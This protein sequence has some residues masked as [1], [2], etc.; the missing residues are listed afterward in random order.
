VLLNGRA[1]VYADV[2]DAIEVYGRLN[3]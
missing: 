1:I 3:A 2:A